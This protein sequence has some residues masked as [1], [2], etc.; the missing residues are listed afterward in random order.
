MD[1]IFNIAIHMDDEHIKEQVAI[2][3]EKEIIANLTKEVGC[4]IF[5]KDRYGGYYNSCG[6]KKGYDEN[7]LSSWA[8]NRFVEFL[9]THK[10]AIIA[11]AA[12]E[13]ADRLARSK[14]GKAILEN[15]KE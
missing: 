3:A 1:H 7:H 5:E 11:G 9:D 6:N 8:K 14:A 2:K 12:K 4:V 10:D 15:L 13:L